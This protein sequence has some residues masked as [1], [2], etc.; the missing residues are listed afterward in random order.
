MRT[1]G[2]DV[3][4]VQ[5]GQGPQTVQAAPISTGLSAPRPPAAPSAPGAPARPVP[6]PP[7]LGGVKAPVITAPP[8]APG[9]GRGRIILIAIL[10]VIVVGIIIVIAAALIGSGSSGSTPTPTPT[11]TAT[12]TP[13]SKNLQSYFGVPSTTA[14]ISGSATA[15]A[16]FKSS[17]GFI[18]PPAHQVAV[19][20]VV[21]SGAPLNAA[22]FLSDVVSGTPAGIVASLSDDWTVMIYGQAEA[23]NTQGQPASGSSTAHPATILILGTQDASGANQLMQS[24]ESSGLLDATKGLFGFYPERQSGTGF[25]SGTYQQIPVRYANFPYAD[26][27]LDWA[28]VLAS[29]G[30]NY[31]VLTGSREAMFFAVDHLSQ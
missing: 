19:I 22:S 13:A 18:Q 12:L 25:S 15:L 4:G 28:M 23:F 30:K 9:H 27:S 17:I 20:N 2:G 11:A 31:L 6:P 21:Q 24:W 29:N 16:D 14:T 26:Q 1:M 8:A 5:T 10:G 3:K 7:P